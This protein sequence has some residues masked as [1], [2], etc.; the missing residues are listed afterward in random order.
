MFWVWA[1][2]RVSSLILKIGSGFKTH[3]YLKLMWDYSP[4]GSIITT[5]IQI[6]MAVTKQ[7]V[8]M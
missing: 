3:T 4:W 8:N 1:L 6:R 7:L 5:F 2:N